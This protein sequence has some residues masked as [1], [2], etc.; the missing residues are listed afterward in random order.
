MECLIQGFSYKF[1]IVGGGTT[2]YI[3]MKWKLDGKDEAWLKLDETLGINL[4][5]I[6]IQIL[7][8]K[9]LCATLVIF[10]QFTP[11]RPELFQL[12]KHTKVAISGTLSQ[13]E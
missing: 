6:M 13:N 2:M 4:N 1:Y 8:F 3:M 5:E 10:C 12:K 7:H 11:K 9:Q